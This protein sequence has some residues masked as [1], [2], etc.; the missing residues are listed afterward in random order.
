M[1]IERVSPELDRIV[2]PDQ[3]VEILGGGLGG[4]FE[5]SEGPV[6]WKE[7]RAI[8]SYPESTEGHGWTA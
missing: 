2:S 7:G 4:E 8:A 3:E 5:A 6:W 1:P